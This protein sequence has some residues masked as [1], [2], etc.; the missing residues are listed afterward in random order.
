MHKVLDP[1][2]VLSKQQSHNP[3]L[4]MP[5]LVLLSQPHHVK[6]LN[7]SSKPTHVKVTSSAFFTSAGQY[8]LG[9]FKDHKEKK[10]DSHC[11]LSP[12]PDISLR[13]LQSPFC[14]VVM[15]AGQAEPC[16][17]L[18]VALATMAHGPDPKA[19]CSLLSAPGQPPPSS[20]TICP[21]APKPVR[22]SKDHT[23][24]R[25]GTDW[26]PTGHMAIC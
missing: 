2:W 11:S 16:S 25:E 18:T 17:V 14:S 21:V 15:V 9:F 6:T 8:H 7:H 12:E 10:L 1:R 22:T 3:D 20:L 26:S 19:A 5:S 24:C 13:F 23:A 4:L